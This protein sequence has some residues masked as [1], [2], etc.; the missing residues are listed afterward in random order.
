MEAHLAHRSH[1]EGK[2]VF[3]GICHAICE[4][5]RTDS[6]KDGREE[7]STDFNRH[8]ASLIGTLQISAWMLA[9]RYYTDIIFRRKAQESRYTPSTSPKLSRTE[10]HRKSC[11]D[12]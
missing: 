11:I 5:S 7:R 9:I 8:A 1:P 3:S 2:E 10:Q 4:R 12:E 6:A